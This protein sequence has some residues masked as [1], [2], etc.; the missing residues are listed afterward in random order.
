[1]KN[2]ILEKLKEIEETHQVKVLYACEDGSRAWGFHADS[3]DYDVRFVFLQDSIKYLTLGT[4]KDAMNFGLSEQLDLSGWDIRKFLQLMGK[5][6]ASVLE[7]LRSPVVYVSEP[8]FVD[9]A[10]KL[11]LQY[12]NPVATYHHYAGL[13]KKHME[14]ISI[15]FPTA[16]GYLHATR[17]LLACQW[18]IHKQGPPPTLFSDL[19]TIAE[20]ESIRAVLGKLLQL[21]QSD[22]N[23]LVEK[24]YDLEKWMDDVL[25]ANEKEK[26]QLKHEKA[27]LEDLD[28]F[29]RNCIS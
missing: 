4:P 21:K 11:M 24:E 14:D 27:G 16:K 3:S 6:N 20:S 13:A 23:L 9:E 2:I 5:S 8:S 19:I 15:L 26:S 1:M 18:V 29:Y 12:F 17:A 25:A 7:W 28:A 10:R 22:N